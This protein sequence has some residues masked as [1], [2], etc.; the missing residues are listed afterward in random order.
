MKVTATKFIEF[1]KIAHTKYDFL[2]TINRMPSNI[3]P[4]ESENKKVDLYKFASIPVVNWVVDNIGHHANQYLKYPLPAE[5]KLLIDG[6]NTY[7]AKKLGFDIDET[8]F[9]PMRGMP[10]AE[11]LPAFEQRDVP[12]LF[13]GNVAHAPSLNDLR[14][15]MC[16]FD[17]HLRIIFRQV[18]EVMLDDMGEH[19]A[20]QIA[21]D[22]AD[23][24]DRRI[25]AM[26]LFA[27]LGPWLRQRRRKKL[28]QSFRDLPIMIAGEVHDPEL[29]IQKNLT[30]LGPTNMASTI[31]LAK[32]AKVVLGDL[33]NFTY[34]TELRPGIAM[35]CGAVLACEEN[36]YMRDTLAPDSFIS[37]LQDGVPAESAVRSVLEGGAEAWRAIDQR[38][39][40][41]Y[42]A[43]RNIPLRV[44]DAAS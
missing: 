21:L 16:G 26:Q 18:V 1:L 23:A 36:R 35:A 17:P 32:R 30:S 12:V 15:E 44:G 42:T 10:R 5:I 37:L 14:E 34:G 38:A 3:I 11:N 31:E 29:S 20:F 27:R 9:L 25:G 41:Q 7:T 4:I 33:A 22:A 13:S 8:S 43:L 28:L 6:G 2:F 19:D 40:E 39:G 24:L